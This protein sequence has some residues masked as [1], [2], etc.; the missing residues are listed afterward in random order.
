MDLLEGSCACPS[1]ATPAWLG[2]KALWDVPTGWWVT[3]SSCQNPFFPHSSHSLVLFNRN[4]FVKTATIFKNTINNHVFFTHILKYL[5]G[6]I[7]LII[8][9]YLCKI[10]LL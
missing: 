8:Q 1:G 3:T 6:F 7:V 4:H 9:M 2:C 5:K 10:A